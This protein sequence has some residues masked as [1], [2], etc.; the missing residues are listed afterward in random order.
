MGE[1]YGDLL[2]VNTAETKRLVRRPPSPTDGGEADDAFGGM[3]FVETD[4]DLRAEDETVG[5]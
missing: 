4:R 3:R 1:E 5:R 2:A